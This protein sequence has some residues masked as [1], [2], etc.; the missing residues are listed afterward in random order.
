MLAMSDGSALRVLHLQAAVGR[1]ELSS[2]S[3]GVAKR[4]A[5][6]DRIAKN[7]HLGSEWCSF[8]AILRSR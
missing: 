7:E 1:A 6:T 3:T 5:G 2:D 4:R 8:F